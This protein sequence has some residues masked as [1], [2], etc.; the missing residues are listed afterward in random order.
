MCG[1]GPSDFQIPLAQ[2]WMLQTF[3]HLRPGQRELATH[4]GRAHAFQLR[5]QEPDPMGSL[6]AALRLLQSLRVLAPHPPQVPWLCSATWRTGKGVWLRPTNGVRQFHHPLT[7]FQPCIAS[8]ASVHTR[9]NAPRRPPAAS[10]CSS[11]TCPGTCSSR[12]GLRPRPRRSPSC[13]TCPCPRPPARPKRR[14]PRSARARR[15]PRQRPRRPLGLLR[16]RP[17][18]RCA[19]CRTLGTSITAS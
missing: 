18:T 14:P 2:H 16:G 6:L 19:A 17:P 5:P 9:A 10:P 11:R 15:S 12:A 13:A 1:R 4:F 8:A 3:S 7:D